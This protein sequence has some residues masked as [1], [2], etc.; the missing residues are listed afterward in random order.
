M[1]W[2]IVLEISLFRLSGPIPT[3]MERS[4]PLTREKIGDDGRMAL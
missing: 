1:M 2:V 3:L 4:L